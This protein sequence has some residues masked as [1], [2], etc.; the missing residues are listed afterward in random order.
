MLPLF[1]FKISGLVIF[2]FST[3]QP[4]PENETQTII[5]VHTR[6]MHI[7]MGYCQTIFEEPI[8]KEKI[9]HYF[10]PGVPRSIDDGIIDRKD[11]YCDRME[12]YK[13]DND[14]VNGKL[15]YRFSRTKR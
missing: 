9:R 12:G 2:G 4:V 1:Y 13:E 11:A 3:H 14:Q 8:S 7:V 10:K 6:V 15:K 5:A